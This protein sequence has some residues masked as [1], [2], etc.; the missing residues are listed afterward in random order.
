[1]RKPKVGRKCWHKPTGTRCK[2]T[3]IH[4]YAPQWPV[5]VCDLEALVQP[6]PNAKIAFTAIPFQDIMMCPW[7][8]FW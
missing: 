7:W 3:K 6:L 5:P 1:M 2:I 4:P 8:M